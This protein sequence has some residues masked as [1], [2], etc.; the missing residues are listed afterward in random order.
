LDDVLAQ[1][2]GNTSRRT[3]LQRARSSHRCFGICAPHGARARDV[4]GLPC[5]M[6]DVASHGRPLVSL[7]MATP[8][9]RRAAAT[10][11]IAQ[12]RSARRVVHGA[13][14]VHYA[15]GLT[16]TGMCR[17]EGACGIVSLRK[18]WSPFPDVCEWN[19]NRYYQDL[20]SCTLKV[21]SMVSDA[22]TALA[23]SFTGASALALLREH[24]LGTCTGCRAG[25]QMWPAKA[26]HLSVSRW[27]RLCYAER[28][29]R[30]EL[31]SDAPQGGWSV[32]GPIHRP[33]GLTAEG[34]VSKRRCVWN[35]PVY[36]R[37]S[38]PFLRRR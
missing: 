36:G 16:A 8:L 1:A 11:G 3:G 10:T 24:G 25:C 28:L 30:P 22:Q 15:A 9:L 29:L 34:C 18:T 27:R 19:R 23:G 12:R 33:V 37:A 20:S 13:V 31:H 2:G 5:R 26:G 7:S 4:H 6:S 14:P 35:R 32:V 17:R 21:P 38:S